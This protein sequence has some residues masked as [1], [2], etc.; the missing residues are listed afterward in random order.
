M[1]AY[2]NLLHFAPGADTDQAY[3]MG[4]LAELIKDEF[5]SEQ[6]DSYGMA[7]IDTVSGKAFDGFIPHQ[8]GGFSISEYY[9]LGISSG[10]FFTDGEREH[11]ERLQADAL[12]GFCLENDYDDYE[13]IPEDRRE[14][15]YEFEDN[16]LRDQESILSVELWTGHNQ[17]TAPG[18][19]TVRLSL[20][21]RDAPYYRSKYAEDLAEFQYTA[22]EFKAVE[23]YAIIE[24][25]RGAL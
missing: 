16:W 25:L 13:A 24:R 11:A 3:K 7:R 9:P 8:K 12:A 5:I 22:D 21:Y 10:R 17:D 20:N 2:D 18:M 4:E 15:L 19:V 23:L 1:K 14:D 6:P